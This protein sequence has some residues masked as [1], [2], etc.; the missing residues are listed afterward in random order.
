MG[1]GTA[2]RSRSS[3]FAG[4]DSSLREPSPRIARIRGDLLAAGYSI[5][6]ES[7]TNLRLIQQAV[8]IGP[9]NSEDIRGGWH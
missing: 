1:Q 3:D 2:D 7:P 4:A 8:T 6:L 9:I 5:C